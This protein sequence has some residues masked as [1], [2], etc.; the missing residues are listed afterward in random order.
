[1]N[2]KNNLEKLALAVQKQ[3]FKLEFDTYAMLRDYICN[4]NSISKINIDVNYP[5]HIPHEFRE[6]EEGLPQY[7]E[8]DVYARTIDKFSEDVN[9]YIVECKGAN[10]KSKLAMVEVSN[11]EFSRNINRYRKIKISQNHGIFGKLVEG[12][13]IIGPY[14]GGPPATFTGDFFSLKNKEFK[15]SDK[16]L[17]NN[18][19]FKGLKQLTTAAAELKRNKKLLMEKK[20]NILIPILV[21]NVDICVVNYEDE[22][23]RTVP[24]LYHKNKVD[25]ELCDVGYM[26]YVYVTNL[27]NLQSL[28]TNQYN[29]VEERIKY[30][31]NG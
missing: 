20:S 11:S 14:Q 18:N 3:G 12:E 15:R 5:L 8:A 24:W 22:T 29:G 2:E 9:H 7:C 16:N 30:I 1:M 23:I 6:A 27:K 26:P 4:D 31:P 21:T 19:L 10:L 25:G 17:D 28:L 13:S